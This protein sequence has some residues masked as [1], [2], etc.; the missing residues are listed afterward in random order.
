M[1]NI[2][3]SIILH[4][5]NNQ[6]DDKVVETFLFPF[7]KENKKHLEKIQWTVS[8]NYENCVQRKHIYFNKTNPPKDSVIFF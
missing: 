7:A 2:Y 4:G 3:K 6:L 5:N 8:R 1:N